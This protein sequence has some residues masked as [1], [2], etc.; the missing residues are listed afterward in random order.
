MESRL[1]ISTGGETAAAGGGAGEGESIYV[2]AA[3]P[4]S[5][6][7]SASLMKRLTPRKARTL[8]RRL[9]RST[10]NK[11]TAPL[12][13]QTT[14]RQA[15]TPLL[16]TSFNTMKVYLSS[17]GSVNSTRVHKEGGKG[18]G[19]RTRLPPL[20][21][22]VPIRATLSLICWINS[23][24]SPSSN[25]SNRSLVLCKLF[26]QACWDSLRVLAANSKAFKRLLAE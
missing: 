4:V 13:T 12:T 6:G 26:N 11:I 15:I 2:G 16:A 3:G 17:K 22:V 7:E 19:I 5:S 24:E 20:P 8:Y 1:T 18:W 10:Q 9:Q 21:E 14:V 25:P 23:S